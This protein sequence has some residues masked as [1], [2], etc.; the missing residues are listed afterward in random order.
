LDLSNCGICGVD[1]EYFAI[2]MENNS[3]GEIFL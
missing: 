2:A 1:M 3:V